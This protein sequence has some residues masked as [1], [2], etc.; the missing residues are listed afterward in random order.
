M[1]RKLI[2]NKK[3]QNVAEY[4]LMIALVIAAIIAMQTYAQRAIQAK[5]RD[6]AGFL[7]DRLQDP[8][9]SGAGTVPGFGATNQYE[10]YYLSTNYTIGRDD[11]DIFRLGT[12]L[13]SYETNGTRTRNTG[14]FQE[15]DYEAADGLISTP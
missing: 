5:V 6:A 12:N 7:T 10:P 15:F 2:K 9:G 11:S 1:F 13:V 4:A 3:A 14:G 8:D